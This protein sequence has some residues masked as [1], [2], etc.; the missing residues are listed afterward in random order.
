M[1]SYQLMIYLLIWKIF[2]NIS[3]LHGQICLY[4][5]VLVKFLAF[6]KNW[7]IDNI[8]SKVENLQKL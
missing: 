6:K 3:C 1:S 7:V 4:T 2:L 8:F 5:Y